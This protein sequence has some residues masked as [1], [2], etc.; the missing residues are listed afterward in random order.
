MLVIGDTAAAPRIRS[1]AR[2]STSARTIAYSIMEAWRE[3]DDTVAFYVPDRSAQNMLVTDGLP[4]GPMHLVDDAAAWTADHAD[5]PVRVPRLEIPG[6]AVIGF[7]GPG[8]N[9]FYV[10]DQPDA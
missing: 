8:G 9:A 4:A 1:I 2:R 3:G 5:L 7:D 10:F 6:G